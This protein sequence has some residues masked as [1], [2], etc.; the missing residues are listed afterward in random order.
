M[1]RTRSDGGVQQVPSVTWRLSFR[2]HHPSADLSAVAERIGDAFDMDPEAVWRAG[3]R[4]PHA[5]PAGQ[6]RRSS[7][8]IVPLP[9]DEGTVVKG[10][11]DALRALTPL[12][13]E[14]ASIVASG[15]RLDFFVGLFV[16][17]MM[18][19]A[20]LPAV[21]ARLAEA[22]IELQL[23]IYAGRWNSAPDEQGA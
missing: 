1:Q 17:S 16:E 4:N 15:G 18:G 14:L 11:E 10:I 2:V 22:Q 8:C 20:L 3:D 21:L 5:K 7:Y 6:L 23:D 19:I 9:D 12:R 13:E